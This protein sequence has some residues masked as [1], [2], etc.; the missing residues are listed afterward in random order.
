MSK[1]TIVVATDLTV[2]SA[3]AAHW[4]RR[5]ATARGARVV[6]AH[7]VELDMAEWMA[8][9]LRI[10]V[11]E[12]ELEA[13]AGLAEA[14][15]RE[16]TACAPDAVD[17]R[18]GPCHAVLADVVADEQ[19]D[20]LVMSKSVKGAVAS[21]FVGSRVLHVASRPPCTLVVVHPEHDEPAE[22]GPVV[23]G[24]DFS[25]AA[26]AAED[27]AAGHAEHLGAPLEVVHAVRPPRLPAL[28]IE[29]P[30]AL[31]EA[32]RWARDA[33]TEDFGRL[34]ADWPNVELDTRVVGG[35]P[36]EVLLEEARRR[37]PRLLVVGQTGFGLKLAELLGSTARKVVKQAPCTVAVV[38]PT[39]G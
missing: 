34:R 10:E 12:G 13:A 7:V 16:H 19:A 29:D 14:W 21:V 32:L 3:P 36:S 22:A 11:G 30:V 39:K 9:R 25:V 24:T 5:L 38:P 31:E 27:F 6:V 35:T 2:D 23:V 1:P 17:V 18:V 33:V 20:L 8:A 15:Y 37:A 4:T 28:G 26:R